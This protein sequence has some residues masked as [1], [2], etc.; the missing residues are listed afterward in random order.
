MWLCRLD[1]P[2]SETL[3]D[4]NIRID[5][6]AVKSWGSRG[7]GIPGLRSPN[8]VLRHTAWD[9]S[10]T[11]ISEFSE[12]SGSGVS[13]SAQHNAKQPSLYPVFVAWFHKF[14]KKHWQRHPHYVVEYV[15][16]QTVSD[17]W[18]HRLTG[19]LRRFKLTFFCGPKWSPILSDEWLPRERRDKV[20]SVPFIPGVSSSW[21]SVLG[22][23][24]KQCFMWSQALCELKVSTDMKY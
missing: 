1:W 18:L 3:P 10:L 17:A 13:S 4:Q 11:L 14:H 5:V 19:T 16:R 20:L 21:F 12:I 6:F 15:S 24:I 23:T 22:L 7:S 2:H 8:Q 9:W